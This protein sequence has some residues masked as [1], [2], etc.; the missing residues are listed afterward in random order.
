MSESVFEYILE[1]VHLIADEGWK[2]LPLYSF[3]PDSGLWR[4]ADARAPVPLAL[5]DAL[6]PA[7]PRATAPESVLP[8]YLARAREL[9]R[10]AEARPPS[11]SPAPA[12]TAD[13]ERIRWF[14][15]PAE[16]AAGRREPVS[17]A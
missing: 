9:I 17:H 4:H 2:L 6:A 14:P 10:A 1:A 16:V 11:A 7:G 12:L 13:F 15:L 8:D 5:S 3:D